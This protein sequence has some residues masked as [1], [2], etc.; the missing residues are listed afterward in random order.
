MSK[1]D[2]ANI[3]MQHAPTEESIDQKAFLI[4]LLQNPEIMVT[5]RTANPP[6]I[7]WQPDIQITR[8]KAKNPPIDW[9]FGNPLPTGP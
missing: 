8:V 6:I 9:K 5:Q 2:A 3:T 4:E 1:A 7:D